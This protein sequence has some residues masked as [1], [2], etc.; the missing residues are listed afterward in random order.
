MT[1]QQ[2]SYVVNLVY[3]YSH[4]DSQHRA[5]MERS[6]ALLK[7]DGL[8]VDWSDQSILPGS[9]ISA[10]I[11]RNMDNADIIVF[12]LSPDF[13][14]SEECM[15]EW[16]RAEQLAAENPQRFYI[17][18][19][20]RDCAWKDLLTKDDPKALPQDGVPVVNFVSQDAA[21]QQVYEGIKAVVNE[22]RNTFTAK[23]TFLAEMGRTD[24]ISQ[25]NINLKDIFVFL[26]L[27]CRSSRQNEP[28]RPAD[29]ITEPEELL[30]K[31]YTLIHGADRSGK[32]ALSRHVLLILAEQSKPALYVDLN[33]VPR[34]AGHDFFRKTY[35]SQFHGD[36]SLW[37]QQQDKTLIMDNLSGR[38]GLIDLVVA[39]KEFFD[40]II[41]TLS[42][43]VFYAFFRDE[44]RLADFEELEIADL[45]QAQQE[46]LIRKRL[47]LTSGNPSLTD[48]YV[49][50]V[51]DRVNSI[52]IDNKVVPRYPFFVLCILQTYEAYMPAG[53]AITSY[54]HCYYALI[55]A[56][57]VRA[58]ISRQDSD[59]NACFNFAEHLAF[60][61]YQRTS[62]SGTTPLDFDDFVEQYRREYVI[63]HAV[64]NRLKHEE[65]GLI[66]PDGQFR[67]AYMHHFFLG[68]FLS[69]GS[70]T[71][72]DIIQ[73]MCAATYVP[74]NYLTLLFT[75]HHTSDLEIIDDIL[76]R[77][78]CTLDDVQA[79]K[80]DSAENRRFQD[81]VSSLPKSILS[82]EN[83]ESERKRERE[84]R[85]YA[86]GRTGDKEEFD[87][88]DG[89]EIQEWVNGIYRVWKN[90]EIMGQILRN[91]YGSITKQKIEEIIAIMADG[92][93]RLVNLVL[94]DEDEIA[95]MAHYVKAKNPDYDIQKIKRDLGWFSFVWT[96][97]NVEHIVKSI[98]VP[99]VSASIRN[100]AERTGTPAYGMIG[101]FTLLDAA[102]ELTEKERTELAR[103]LK[104]HP[105]PFV[106]GVLSIRTQHY[107]NTHRSKANVEQSICSLL[108]IKYLPRLVQGNR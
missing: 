36:Y 28:D 108:G 67:T 16:R 107:M 66:D 72:R 7:T 8:L 70:P 27:L 78:M 22:L 38:S 48:A 94:K 59:I 21:W 89:S 57:L 68:R 49:D 12:L 14:A 15:K 32:T 55:V 71:N 34:D 10:A 40:R 64:I 99:E 11:R 87:N 9:S 79:A 96:I 45:T 18:I 83:V 46:T 4:R 93:L 60:E 26:P 76:L 74:A 85:D 104:K 31:K 92:G 95:D 13:I 47:S 58:G 52:I 42:S 101:Y 69:K 106:R 2:S 61:T 84:A 98:N 91:K 56:S 51:E 17:P 33:Q 6:L 23:P 35:Y 30:R 90:N 53:L 54:G 50:R 88:D 25:Q 86:A 1:T 5:S 29:E 82:A 73:R 41:I 80:L 62:R 63:S 44:S 77:T 39:A 3:S 100:V 37:I 81:I 75:I 19:I 103:L 97:I 24:F 43:T 20:V 102:L 65:F 105:D